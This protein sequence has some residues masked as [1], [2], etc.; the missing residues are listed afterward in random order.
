MFFPGL[1]ASRLIS[2]S[3]KAVHGSLLSEARK[4]SPKRASVDEK[5]AEAKKSKNIMSSVDFFR[6]KYSSVPT[7]ETQLRD[8]TSSS[9]IWIKYH[10]G[11]SDA[12]RKNIRWCDL[13]L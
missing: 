12:V 11:Y 1:P 8:D 9:R 6:D 4:R 13:W 7:T 3:Q 5:G 2:S 10:E